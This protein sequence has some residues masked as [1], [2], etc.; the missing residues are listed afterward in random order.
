MGYAAMGT[1]TAGSV[2][3]P[4]SQCG[5][6][7]LKP[8][9]GRVSVRGVIPLSASLDHVGPLTRT[10]GDAAIMLRAVA[11]YDPLDEFSSDVPIED[12]VAALNEPAKN[13][14]IAVPRDFF[15]DEL[16]GEVEDLVEKAIAVLQQIF[17]GVREVK[18]DVPTDRALQA[19]ESYEVHA[20]DVARTP[21]LY[22]AETLRR[23]RSGENISAAKRQE[24]QRELAAERRKIDGIFDDFEVLVTPATPIPA[25][26]LKELQQ[27]MDLLRPRELLLLRNTRPFNVWGLPAISV[28]CGFTSEGLPVGVQIA[29]R[30]WQE[31]TVLRVAQA[32][33][34]MTGWKSVVT[35][36]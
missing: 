13:V 3:E 14:R 20:K 2:R 15:F 8:S 24:L 32:Y 22:Q 17:G 25:P 12:Y 7:G 23:I 28:P 10:V 1:D 30:R 31:S 9:Y 5:V 36:E 33:E 6:V 27:D 4:A 34:Q 21:D 26:N 29:G 18:L 35:E 19:A 16:D 11:G